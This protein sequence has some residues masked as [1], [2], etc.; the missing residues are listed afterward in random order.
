MALKTS[1]T[2]KNNLTKATLSLF[3]KTAAF[4]GTFLDFTYHPHKYV[5]KTLNEDYG[6][7]V[8]NIKSTVSKLQKRNLIEK[9][10]AKNGEIL[11]KLTQDGELLLLKEKIKSPTVKDRKGG[12]VVIVFD[13]PES[14][15]T[16]RNTM[17]RQL[18]DFGFS[19]WQKSVWVSK[20]DYFELLR[21]YLNLTGLGD[22][23]IL[24]ESYQV[25]KG[26]K[27]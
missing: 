2:V 5:Y 13:I 10:I 3:V 4:S 17:R 26:K 8:Q 19:M 11:F 27:S 20:K 23:V 21:K 14:A 7:R 15:R 18:K 24:F 1:S 9:Q 16:I 25:F 22:Y 12:W 6:F